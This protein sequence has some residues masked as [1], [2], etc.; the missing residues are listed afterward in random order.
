[1]E[2]RKALVRRLGI[3][4]ACHEMLDTHIDQK[5][6][7]EDILHIYEMRPLRSLRVQSCVT[8][9]ETSQFR[10]CK[11]ERFERCSTKCLLCMVSY[12]VS[13]EKGIVSCSVLLLQMPLRQSDT[14]PKYQRSREIRK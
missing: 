6:A 13:L 14:R 5:I 4:S 9:L 1:M 10:E 2:G 8:R 3:F 11:I 7:R 12:T